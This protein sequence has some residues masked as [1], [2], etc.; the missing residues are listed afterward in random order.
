MLYI[1]I[2]VYRI[3]F[4]MDPSDE[5]SMVVENSSI[6]KSNS[7]EQGLHF[8]VLSSAKRLK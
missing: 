6:I 3:C 4:P 5:F 2:G 1:F 7:A 8:T